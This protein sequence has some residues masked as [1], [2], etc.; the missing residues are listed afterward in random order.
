MSMTSFHSRI[1]DSFFRCGLA[2]RRNQYFVFFYFVLILSISRSDAANTTDS[3]SCR[4]A[5]AFSGH[6]RSLVLGSVRASTRANLFDGLLRDG[7][8]GDVFA[9]VT[10]GDS[11]P[12][13]RQSGDVSNMFSITHLS[14]IEARQ[15][16]LAY[17]PRKIA[18]AR[19]DELPL[20]PNSC[21]SGFPP[22]YPR[23]QLY[24]IR[25]CHAL[26]EA[27]ELEDNHQYDW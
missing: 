6:A 9:R 21:K 14:E 26:V 17:R 3:S 11:V 27:A 10:L 23:R 15:L 18:F 16:L 7:C 24:G 1:I 8:I 4:V 22:P 5:F 13:D 20:V 12:I 2:D 25:A 19:D